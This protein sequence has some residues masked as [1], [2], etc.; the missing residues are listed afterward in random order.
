MSCDRELRA[1]GPD[2][3]ELAAALG[4]KS[5]RT[6]ALLGLLSLLVA[7]LLASFAW[8][9]TGF[10]LAGLFRSLGGEDSLASAMVWR[11]RAPRLAMGAL[12]GLGLGVAGA[13]SQAVLRNPLASPFT[14]GISSGAAFGAALAICWSPFAHAGLVSGLAILFSL[15]T[16]GV[17]LGVSSLRQGGNETLVLSGVAVMFLFSAMTSYLQYMA[18]MADLQRI[19]FWSFGSLS[20]AGW[21]EIGAAS[22]MIL[23]PLPWIYWKAWDFNLLLCGDETAESLGV[24]VGRLKRS[25][26]ALMAVLSA[27]SIC[28]CGVVG[29]VGLVAPHMARL[30]VGGDHRRLLPAAA[31]IGASLLVL[32]DLLGRSL[33]APQVIP[34]GI[35]TAF[36][37]VPFFFWLLFRRSRR[38]GL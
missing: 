12:A 36:L 9:P 31:C 23:T 29:F 26:I 16:A 10:D 8:G 17:A 34:V 22:L 13:V 7:S 37:G 24:N 18:P 19:V 38:C 2:T 11:L 30:L 4:A 33:Y 20:R 35:M 5:R 27:G 1:A 25:S 32:A 21:A 14:L 28:F 6:L 15:L 3:A